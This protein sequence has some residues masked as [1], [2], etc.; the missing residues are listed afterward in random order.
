MDTPSEVIKQLPPAER[1]LLEAQTLAWG[2]CARSSLL[3]LLRSLFVH[4]P[5]GRAF[6]NDKLKAAHDALRRRGLLEERPQGQGGHWQVKEPV[7]STAYLSLLENTPGEKLRLAVFGAAAYY[8]GERMYYWPVGDPELSSAVVRIA[9]L[10]DMP[11][12][13][14]KTLENLLGY[15][16]DP[17]RLLSQAFTG[18][19]SDAILGRMTTQWRDR[20]VSGRLAGLV[21]YWNEACLP[22][23]N[24]AVAALQRPGCDLPLDIRY[25]T[26]EILLHQ[27]KPQLA[28]RLLDNLATPY[29][30]ALRA[31]AL[32]QEGHWQE[33]Q[34]GFEAAL[35]AI[36]KESGGKKALLPP[37]LSLYYGLAL[38]AQ[39]TPQAIET[40]RKFCLTESGSRTP[41][42]FEKWGLW[43]HAADV[44][45]GNTA[46]EATA[47]RLRSG[48]Q[49]VYTDDLWRCLL[50]AWLGVKPPPAS[51]DK[52][53]EA[54]AI[55]RGRLQA[56][57][58]T[59]LDAQMEA[60]ESV[61]RGGEAPPV[62]FA[63][64]STESWRSV[65][66]ALQSLA[67]D[68]TGGEKIETTRIL[69]CLTLGK[70][71]S[72]DAIDPLEQKRGARGW[73]KPKPL[74]L[75]KLH[76][77]EKLEPWDARVAR[78]VRSDPHYTKRFSLDRA[79]AIMAL[80]GH[81]A[82]VLAHAEDQRVDVVEGAPE[83]EV[84]RQGDGYVMRITPPMREP[85]QADRY[86]L[87]ADE[88]REIEVLNLITVMKDSPQRIRVI[89]FTPA[90]RRA[91]VLV[92]DKLKIPANAEEELQKT[93]HA[94][95]GHFQIQSDHAEAAREVEAQTRLR[96]ELSPVGEGVLLRLVAAP[97][98]DEGP[99]LMPG[100]GRERIMAA[101]RGEGVGTQRDLKQEKRHLNAVLDALPFLSPP[102]KGDIVAEWRVEEPE[103]ALSLV[104]TLPQLPA[105]SAVDWP[106]GK[107]VRVMTVDSKQLGITVRTERDWLSVS[108]QV[109]LDD[110]LVLELQQ[111]LE[112]SGAGRGRFLPMGAG[113]YAALTD[114]L[115]AQLAD[116]AAVAEGG[117]GETLIPQMA[118]AW[119]EEALQGTEV[120]LDKAFRE[121]VERLRA[122]QEQAHPLPLNLQAELRPYQ[123]DGYAWAMR[124]AGAGF[125]ACLADDMGLGK[126]LQALAVLLTRAQG[127]PALVVAPTSVCGNWLAEAERFAPSLDFQLYGEGDRAGMIAAAKPGDV[128]LVSYTLMQQSAETFADKTWHT[129]VVDEAQAIKNAAAKRSQAMFDLSADFRMA[130]SGTPVE[131]RLAELWSI[132]R[133]CNPGLLGTLTRFSTRFAGPIERDRDRE[134]QHLLRRLIAPFV[135]RR[136]KGQVLQELPPRTEL[137][138][139]V[140]PEAA[141][142][143]HYE[144]LR[145]LAISEAQVAVESTSGG[146]AQFH[147]LAQLTKLRRA[148]CD[149]RLVSPDLGIVGAK[150][151]AF[152]QLAVELAANGHK[153]LVFS[154]F[155]DFLTLLKAPLDEAGIPYQYLDGAT[156]AAERTR[157]VNAFQAGVGELFLISL[158]AGG[159]GLNLTAADY[160]VIADPW[161]NPAAEDQAMG[162]AHR[163]GQLR[164]V[165]VYRLVNKGSLEERIVNLHTE[166]RALAE[167][168]LAE[169]ESTALPSAEDLIALI[170]G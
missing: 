2:Y 149:P 92:A 44:R 117:K 52:E 27:A 57:E 137:T 75:S 161:W 136:T 13:E 107:P 95:T 130:L 104:E 114:R 15:S 83:M 150:V 156:P 71:G 66:A 111:L 19:L 166:K 98:G 84:V 86:G 122:A 50:R 106:K 35:K 94:L 12:T 9:L 167:G 159:F 134:A 138:L 168:I 51:Q 76:G 21:S 32:V 73:G 81:P 28:L 118:A 90:Q 31:A 16:H 43:V 38:L 7:R 69:W 89:R 58:F 112:W 127:G 162:R 79:A 103:D 61:Y 155:V 146:Q 157:R 34:A 74:S 91:A 56:V 158:K 116:L 67:G 1:Q 141:E 169:G 120:K 170:R 64:G 3:P 8:P 142:A 5:D 105:I 131:N 14:L 45:L 55:L 59:W 6:D 165:T 145:R 88:K 65:L 46:L 78:A 143:A 113:V 70:N 148:A 29:A 37:S 47:F 119:L 22:T 163:I 20:L 110:G 101:L 77:N 4:H 102:A 164:P 30:Q 53:A 60:S 63:P 152:G 82:V 87:E 33:A 154:Q 68:T 93:L 85:V 99:R 128:I 25:R 100:V 109:K 26:A 23:L 48:K 40:A 121:R 39:Q 62:F 123:E 151:Q 72:I 124:L 97:L 80:V 153:T 125:G 96:A 36:K 132:M 24:W 10:T 41:S 18:D 126:T 129:L 139:T 115:R 140:T 133:F 108:G 144:A 160:V 49:Y 17:S 42:P 135:L 54:L 147:I 11:E